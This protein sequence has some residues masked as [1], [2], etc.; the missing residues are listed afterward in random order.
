MQSCGDAYNN[1]Y[2]CVRQL[3]TPQNNSTLTRCRN[4]PPTIS[5][6]AYWNMTAHDDHV[7]SLITL[8]P[9]LYCEFD[10]AEAFEELYEMKAD[11]WQLKNLAYSQ[12]PEHKKVKAA[13]A[14]RLADLKACRGASCRAPGGAM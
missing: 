2:H 7:P 1:T 11:P 14:A 8:P 13:M 5:V 9:R 12:K 3:V 10:D 6:F 4:H